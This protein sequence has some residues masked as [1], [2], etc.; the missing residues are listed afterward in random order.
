MSNEILNEGKIGC[1]HRFVYFIDNAF[2]GKAWWCD[3]PLC[4][5]QEKT[6]QGEKIMFPANAYI[7]TPNPAFGGEAVYA[8]R[9][10]STGDV[11]DILPESERVQ[12]KDLVSRLN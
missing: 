11:K 1:A 7:R 4:E 5:R 8:H 3:E 2:D 9:A 10:D 6:G 12:H